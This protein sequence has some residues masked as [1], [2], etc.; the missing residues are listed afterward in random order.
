MLFGSH[1]SQF[2]EDTDTQESDS[3]ASA[4]VKHVSRM[5]S[6]SPAPCGRDD[7]GDGLDSS[8]AVPW[9]RKATRKVLP[10]KCGFERLH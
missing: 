7:K 6:A 4:R 2:R 5:P 10:G 1:S 3:L 9:R 8:A